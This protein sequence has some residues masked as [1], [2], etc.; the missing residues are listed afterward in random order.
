MEKF[1]GKTGISIAPGTATTL[2]AA[3]KKITTLD[4]KGIHKF[5]KQSGFNIDK[6]LSSGGRVKLQGGKGVNTCIRGVIEEEQKKAMK[7]N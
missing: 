7:G 1:H 4:Q 3:E 5:L 2:E 6:C